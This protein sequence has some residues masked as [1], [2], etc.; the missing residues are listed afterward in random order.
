MEYDFSNYFL[1]HLTF[2]MKKKPICSWDPPIPNYI[3]TF[4]QENKPMKYND[5]H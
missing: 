1:F 3:D 5:P 4:V 2:K